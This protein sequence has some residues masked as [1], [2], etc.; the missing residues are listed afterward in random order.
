MH[1][2]LRLAPA[3]PLEAA[4]FAGLRYVRDTDPGLLRRRSGK[5]FSYLDAKGERVREHG[6]LRRIRALAIPPAWSDVWICPIASGHLQASGRD[7]RGRKQY[8]YHP[9]WRQAR[10]ET[11]FTRTAAFGEALP[12][13]RRRV[14]D[15]L[16]R[17]GLPRDKVLATVVRLL[18][19]TLI[20][21]GNEEYAR[22]NKSYGLTTL[23]RR[24]VEVSGSTLRFR[25]RGKSG[26]LHE[27]GV[28]DRRVATVVK[29][30]QDIPGYEL[31]SYVDEQGETRTI[32]SQDVNDYLREIAGDNF[33]AK[34]F[35]TWA[36]SVLALTALRSGGSFESDAD[37]KRKIVEAVKSVASRL[38]NTPSIC[39]QHY[40]HPSLIATYLAGDLEAA[41]GPAET[42]SK[43]DALS[44]EETSLLKFLRRAVAPA[45]GK[46]PVPASGSS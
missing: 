26:K 22:A 15:D 40:I 30:C 36:G 28:S 21:V 18:E 37:A 6:T 24:H 3:D 13:I 44:P 34:D 7:A 14:E 27:V 11:K 43:G 9:R 42:G 41:L 23:R 2:T 29:R 10:D 32:D 12:G 8:R 31:F 4:R 16:A 35:R 1:S 25:F 33:T 38:G 5:G 20:R 39:R 45:S 19:T 46:P 17:P